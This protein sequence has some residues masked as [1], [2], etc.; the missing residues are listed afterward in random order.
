MLS[1]RL[2]HNWLTRHYFHLLKSFPILLKGGFWSKKTSSNLITETLVFLCQMVNTIKT[3]AGPISYQNMDK[4]MYK[5]EILSWL[6][7]TIVNKDK[8]SERPY[9]KMAS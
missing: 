7:I 5:R 9:C 1:L 6:S 3:V 8:S 2:P 4:L